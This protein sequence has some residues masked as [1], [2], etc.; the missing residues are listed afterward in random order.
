MKAFKAKVCGESRPCNAMDIG[1]LHTEALGGMLGS[2]CIRNY[3]LCAC[4]DKLTSMLDHD[5][6]ATYLEC[7]VNILV[8]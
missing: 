7:K 3:H 5:I 6:S 8:A 2:I 1:C 4:E